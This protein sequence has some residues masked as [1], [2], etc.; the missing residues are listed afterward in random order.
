[1]SIK[2]D[3]LAVDWACRTS[4]N[5]MVCGPAARAGAQPAANTAMMTTAAKRRAVA[6]ISPVRPGRSAVTRSFTREV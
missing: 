5:V 1:V 4:V 2:P 6:M 3:A